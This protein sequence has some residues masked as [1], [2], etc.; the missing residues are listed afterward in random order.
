MNKNIRDG[1]AI[2]GFVIFKMVAKPFLRESG[3]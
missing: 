3:A 2:S 1:V